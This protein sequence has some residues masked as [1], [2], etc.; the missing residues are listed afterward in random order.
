MPSHAILYYTHLVTDTVR[1]QVAKLREELDP[2]FRLFV[3][4]CCA[5]RSDL[6]PLVGGGVEVRCYVRDDL[7]ALPYA[8]QLRNVDWKTLRRNPDLAIMRFFRGNPDFDHYWVVEYDVRFAGNWSDI[9]SDL[10][11]SSADLLCAHLTE[12]RQ[13]PDWM[14][15]DSFSS[16]DEPVGEGGLVRAFL[17]FYR[18]SR[19]LMRAIDER[20]RRDWTGHPE[21]LWP[22][23]CRA[24]GL[25]VEEIGGTGATVPDERKGRYY[26]SCMTEA[27]IFLS[28]FSAWPAYSEKSDFNRT[29]PTGILW[30]PVK[31]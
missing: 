11:R 17:P 23:I 2:A 14:H 10:A 3:I 9:V 22:T 4:G 15:W 30:H 8:G 29:A 7:R 6:D 31:E 20:C 16:G 26:H 28:T 1:Q 13:N 18:M 12:F 19:P 24:V 21:V 25:A 5:E 27:G